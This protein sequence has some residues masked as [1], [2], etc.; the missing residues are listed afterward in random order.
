[1]SSHDEMPDG[2]TEK[3]L[4]TLFAAYRDACPDPEPNPDFMP[5]LWQRID[6]NR[7][8]AFRFKRVAQGIITAAAAA[9]LAMGAYLAVPQPPTPPS[10]LELLAAGQPPDNIA[11][12]EI[13]QTA[14]ETR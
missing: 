6:A 4:L 5:R 12:A 3:R 14:H 2:A 8:I 1:M 13:V 10:Y 7:S 11:D 9:A